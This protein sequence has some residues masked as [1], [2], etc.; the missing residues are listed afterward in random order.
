M[1]GR[2]AAAGVHQS[3]PPARPAHLFSLAL[4]LLQLLLHL[5]NDLVLL[6][7]ILDKQ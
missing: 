2:A 3:S 1:P 5:L 4:Q 6:A 7:G